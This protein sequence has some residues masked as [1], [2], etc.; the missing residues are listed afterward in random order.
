MATL[1]AGDDDAVRLAVISLLE[2]IRREQ[3]E[4]GRRHVGHSELLRVKEPLPIIHC[5]SRYS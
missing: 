4:F 2:L 3:S 5:S 1:L